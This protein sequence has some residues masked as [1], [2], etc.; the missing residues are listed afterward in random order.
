M[1]S[2][3]GPRQVRITEACATE[4]FDI[5][6]DDHAEHEISMVV[7]E[8]CPGMELRDAMAASHTMTK[9]PASKISLVWDKQLVGA[10]D[11]ACNRT[12]TGTTWLHSFLQHLRDAP[13]EIQSLIACVPECETFRFGNG[14]TQISH[15]RW[16]LPTM[17]GGVL[18]TFW[19]SVVQ[20]PSLGLLLGRDLLE[21]TGA[22]ISCS[23]KALR[24]E[25]L[26]PDVSIPLRQ[27]AA[28]HF[29][30][31]L[32]PQEWRRP[33]N[34]RWRKVGLDGVVELQQSTKDWFNVQMRIKMAGLGSSSKCK[35]GLIAAHEHFV[36]EQSCL[37]ADVKNSGLETNEPPA[38]L[39]QDMTT[40]Q[41]V[42]VPATSTSKRSGN[43]SSSADCES[44]G[45][46]HT[47]RNC[48]QMASHDAKGGRKARMARIL[49]AFV[50]IATTISSLSAIPVSNGV[51]G[52][53]VEASSREHG[54]KQG[55]WLRD[56]SIEHFEVRLSQWEI[57]ENVDGFATVWAPGFRS[58]KIRFWLEWWRPK[59]K[60]V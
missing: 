35:E 46:R 49:S 52:C 58:W 31:P 8:H 26:D 18:M 30:L 53:P 57:W 29:M 22:D 3:G 42:T 12:C 17:I 23:R 15:E 1:K 9:G 24:C 5:A 10:L 59:P 33:D 14:G 45:F 21:A 16:R 25:H 11:T 20:V 48:Q 36:T 37:A 27:L 51:V 32:L 28:G 55:L 6:A 19:T 7:H 60:K 40:Q 43:G 44:R 2:N 54:C 47:P 56:T 13:I 39:V 34:R 41:F 50:A 38:S 4:H